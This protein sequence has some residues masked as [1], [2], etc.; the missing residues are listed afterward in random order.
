MHAGRVIT[1]IILN[2]ARVLKG[3]SASD[4]F[5]AQKGVQHIK[6]EMGRLDVIVIMQIL[7]KNKRRWMIDD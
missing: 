2:G 7:A 6:Q 5:P 3:S 1:H 4:T